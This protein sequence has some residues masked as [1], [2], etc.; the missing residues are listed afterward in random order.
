[1]LNIIIN[2]KIKRNCPLIEK[3]PHHGKGFYNYIERYMPNYKV[4][5]KMLNAKH[6]Y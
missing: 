6:Y 5:E 3:V 2:L 1:M 4:A